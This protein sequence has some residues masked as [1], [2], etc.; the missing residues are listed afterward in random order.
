MDNEIKPQLKT[1]LQSREGRERA[2]T[3][4]ELRGILNYNNDRQL[5]IF[6]GELRK[7]GIPILF[8]TDKPAGYYIPATWG[9]LQHGLNSFRSYIIDFCIQR[10]YIKKAGYLRLRPPNQGVLF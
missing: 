7:E 9:E 10:A 4:R 2:I 3:R 1:I 8:A 6:I 5:R